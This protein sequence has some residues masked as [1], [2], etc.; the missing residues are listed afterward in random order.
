MISESSIS[1]EKSHKF[2]EFEENIYSAVHRLLLAKN[3]DG[4]K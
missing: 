4:E 1:K 2:V 3:A